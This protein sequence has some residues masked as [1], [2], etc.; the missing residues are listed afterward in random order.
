MTYDDQARENFATAGSKEEELSET[1]A[2]RLRRKIDIHRSIDKSTLNFAAILGLLKATK[3]TAEEYNWLST[4]FFIAFF[5]FQLPQNLALQKFPIGVWIG[6]NC[7]VWAAALG[8]QAAC[9][10]FT[11]LMVCRFILGACEGCVIPG[12]ML[13]TAMFYTHKEQ[14][15]RTGYWFLMS[16][17]TYLFIFLLYF[18]LKKIMP[19]QFYFVL[20]ASFTL[21]ASVITFLTIPSSPSTAWFLTAEE[22]SKAILR[23]K[24]NETEF[25]DKTFRLYQVK[26]AIR[27]IK[28]WVW[29]LFC[30]LVAIPS[31]LSAQVS[32]IVV[33]FGYTFKETT[34]LT[35]GF[36]LIS[37]ISM[38]VGVKLIDSIKNSR[39]WMG[40][41]WYVASTVGAIL[42]IELS[43]N[44]RAGL[45]VAIYLATLCSTPFVV[46]L[47]WIVS[48]TAG[49]TKRLIVQAIILTG[50][51]F[52]NII[53]PQMWKSKYKPRNKIP[54]MIIIMCYIACSIIMISMRFYLR[55]L[56]RIKQ[57]KLQNR[58]QLS[59]ASNRILLIQQQAQ[60]IYGACYL[61]QF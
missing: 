13:V 54:W 29:F 23:V 2:K 35:C 9:K 17:I 52:G 24:I 21:L 15:V 12:F 60:Q 1:E 45:L 56:N 57:S 7:L 50:Y 55:S 3:L 11:Q 19:W 16:T 39:G 20:N 8:L 27:D 43:W 31:S 25:E 36:G 38:W 34:L 40:A 5:I 14:S 33:T 61:F 30:I 18:H 51:C 58:L 42:L 41:I 44:N 53:G 48:S 22:R 26:E 59:P 46:V 6:S 47:G 28:T 49:Y 4:I 10:N 32:I 37:I